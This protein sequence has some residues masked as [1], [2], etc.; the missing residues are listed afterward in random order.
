LETKFVCA[1]TLIGLKKEK[2]G[3]LEL[4]EIKRTVKQLQSVR[5]RH[6]TANNPQDKKWL[7]DLDESLRMNLGIA[8][9]SAGDLSH[10]TAKL[11]L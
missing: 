1:N 8:M 5:E 4:P 3:R 6:L 11:L 9:E 10:E 7:Q 2:Q